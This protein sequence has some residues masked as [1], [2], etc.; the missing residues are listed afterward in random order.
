MERF[1]TKNTLKAETEGD[2]DCKRRDLILSRE[3]MKVVDI[4]NKTRLN[5]ENHYKTGLLWRR[6][7]VQLAT[8]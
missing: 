3:D 8:E 4:L 7:D 6:D 1:G 5:D 2:P